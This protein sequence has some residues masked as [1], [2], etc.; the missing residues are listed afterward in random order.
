ME[1]RT[2]SARTGVL[3]IGLA[4]LVFSVGCVRRTICITSEPAGAL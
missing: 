2:V 4:S 1:V 3:L